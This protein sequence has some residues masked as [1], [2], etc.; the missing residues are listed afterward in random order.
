MLNPLSQNLLAVLSAF[1]GALVAMTVGV[2]HRSLCALIS[3][4]AGTLLATTALVIIPEGVTHI[5]GLP[6]LIGLITGYAIF[7]LLTRF[8]AH[9]CPA[10]SASHFEE[11]VEAHEKAL[12][13]S[14]AIAL[15]I[16]CILDG[17]A[18]T[19]GHHLHASSGT[20]IFV[21]ILIHKFP[22][23]LA[24]TALMMAAGQSR[25]K[26]LLIALALESTG[27]IGW[28][29][30]TSF[31]FLEGFDQSPW[32]HGLMA[33]IGGGFIYLALHAMINESRK[34]SIRLT[35][36]YFILGVGLIGLAKFIF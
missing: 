7:Y 6:V 21:T 13:I 22:E 19:L 4:A 16:H 35:S 17:L 2:T 25:W 23:G 12:A 33:H 20:S 27:L 34:H 8:V 31:E 29:A 30:G 11:H 9:V 14:V 1:L 28:L 10:C 3:I 5:G 26:A 18:V 24:L 15:A 36:C 32:I